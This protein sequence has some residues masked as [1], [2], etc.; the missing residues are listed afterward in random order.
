[1]LIGWEAYNYFNNCTAVELM[2]SPNETKWRKD[3]F[4]DSST[5]Y[6]IDPEQFN[7]SYKTRTKASNFVWKMAQYDLNN[8]S[9]M[10]L[11]QSWKIS[12]HHSF[13]NL[14]CTRHRLNTYA[15]LK[16]MQ[17]VLLYA[18]SHYVP[19]IYLLCMFV[20]TQELENRET[21][22]LVDR[23]KYL[24]LY[25]C[26]KTELT[27]LGYEVIGISNYCRSVIWRKCLCIEYSSIWESRII[28]TTFQNS[29]AKQWTQ[30]A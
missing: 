14:N 21:V 3:I 18:C 7:S 22:L 4:K 17:K 13:I 25:P 20:F 23:Y 12:K 5:N 2:I 26:S 28:V 19:I 11:P 8:F 10:N 1:M 24:D 27:V 6:G 30:L 9:K 16:P 29:T 15:S